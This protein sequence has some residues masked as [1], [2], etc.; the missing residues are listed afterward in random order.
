M[1][2]SIPRTLG[3]LGGLE[4]PWASLRTLGNASSEGSRTGVRLGGMI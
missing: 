4:A 1:T 3:A 2:I